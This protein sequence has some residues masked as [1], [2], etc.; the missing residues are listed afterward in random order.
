MRAIRRVLTIVLGGLAMYVAM[1]A[2][3]MISGA[4]VHEG[5]LEPTYEEFVS[6]NAAL[7]AEGEDSLAAIMFDLTGQ[8]AFRWGRMDEARSWWTRG[9]AFARARR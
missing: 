5:L 8:M 1:F 9:G 6:L 2:V 7:E 4:V 3:S